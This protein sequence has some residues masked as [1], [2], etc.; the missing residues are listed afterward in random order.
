M[1]II[2]TS[3]HYCRRDHIHQGMKDIRLETKGIQV[4]M[5]EIKL[6]TS[7]VFTYTENSQNL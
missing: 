7:A 4:V 3:N 1:P 6:L 5:E 2:S